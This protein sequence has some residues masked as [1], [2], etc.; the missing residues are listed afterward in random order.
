MSYSL[1]QACMDMRGDP[2]SSTEWRVLLVLCRYAGEDGT[3][4]PTRQTIA[5]A[6]RLNVRSVID[7][8]H[9]L[10]ENGLAGLSQLAKS[11]SSPS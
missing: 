4:F 1:V 5:T 3:C 10:K 9:A 2:L 8:L 7:A 11:A 6:G